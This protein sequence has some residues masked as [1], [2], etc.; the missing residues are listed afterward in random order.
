ME[1]PMGTRL[2]PKSFERELRQKVNDCLRI[3]W[4]DKRQRW[5][6]YQILQGGMWVLERVIEGPDGEYVDL[7]GRVIKQALLADPWKRPKGVQSILD[8][9]QEKNRRRLERNRERMRDAC[10]AGAVDVNRS[11]REVKTFDMKTPGGGGDVRRDQ[12]GG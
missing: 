8:E 6:L 2:C 9:V 5:F 3:R 11:S 1:P 4:N 12:D 10:H 7:D